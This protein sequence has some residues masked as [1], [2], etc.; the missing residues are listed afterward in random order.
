MRVLYMYIIIIRFYY[1]S[2]LNNTHVY[3]FYSLSFGGNR[4]VNIF[5]HKKSCEKSQKKNPTSKIP[6]VSV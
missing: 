3:H 4:E 1:L 5:F 2:S 6:G